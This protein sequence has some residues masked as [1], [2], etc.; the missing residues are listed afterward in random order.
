[1]SHL[2]IL[3]HC[4]LKKTQLQFSCVSSITIIHFALVLPASQFQP[5]PAVR[6]FDPAFVRITYRK[7]MPLFFSSLH[8][9]QYLKCITSMLRDLFT[10]LQHDLQTHL[11]Q[12]QN[13]LSLPLP[14]FTVQTKVSF[15]AYRAIKKLMVPEARHLA[16][17]SYSN[18]GERPCYSTLS[19]SKLMLPGQNGKR[20]LFLK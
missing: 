6:F 18:N 20:Q 1:M 19:G 16:G 3:N 9:A 11:S 17:L 7:Q 13:T 5:L 8:N 4:A 15:F 10:E 2:L 14:P 12:T